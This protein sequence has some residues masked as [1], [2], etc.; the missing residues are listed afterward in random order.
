MSNYALENFFDMT[1]N[2]LQSAVIEVTP[3]MA[4]YWL[5]IM[6]KNRAV[7]RAT[8]SKYAS[9]ILSNAWSFNHQG[10][11]FGRNRKLVDGQH[12]LH[13]IISS[14]VS[15]KLLVFINSEV[16]GID[17]HRP[18]SIYDELRI[19][20]EAEWMKGKS[21][22]TA[23]F[24]MNFMKT[25]NY[26]RGQTFSASA[27]LDFAVK[28]EESLT[29]T[30]ELFRASRK[31][32]TQAAVRGVV[33]SASYH[34]ERDILDDFVAKLYSGIVDGPHESSVIRLRE[35][36][37]SASRGNGERERYSTGKRTCRALKAFA[38]GE[39]LRALYEPKD[40]LYLL[41]KDKW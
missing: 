26:S 33:A 5:S 19:G 2:E 21:A 30:Q 3:D 29:M 40:M 36:L 20:G 38:N 7:S 18:R 14:G 12:R 24:M 28:N 9:D 41:P 17:T 6:G 15:L 35:Y 32:I 31:G 34:V 39:P 8:V 22:A 25:K 37:I 13:A 1:S 4:M 23:A 16:Q 11:A 27:V 10:I